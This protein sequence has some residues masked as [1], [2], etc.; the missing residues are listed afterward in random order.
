MS[1]KDTLDR[2]DGLPPELAELYAELS[3]IFLDERPSFGPE[4]RN[5]LAKEWTRPEPRRR[6]AWMR[7]ALAASV[8]ALVFTSLA[9]P[10]ARASLVDGVQAIITTLRG[11]GEA[12][13]TLEEVLFPEEES[14]GEPPLEVPAGA[15]ATV[16]DAGGGDEAVRLPPFQP[17]NC[18]F[19]MLVDAESDRELARRYYPRD[20]QRAG[21]GGTVTLQLWVSETG[22]VDH[23]QLA[24]GSEIQELNTAAL[25]AGRALD[26]QPAMRNG[27]PVGTWVE[28]DLVF[29][30]SA[31]FSFA[32]PEILETPMV[33][34]VD[35]WEPPATWNDAAVIPSP[36]LLESQELLRVALGDEPERLEERFGPLDNILSGEVPEG[37]NA[38]RWREDVTR[39]L[40]EA[41]VRDPENPAPYL[42]LAR[43]RRKQGLRNDA[44][45]LFEEGLKR[46]S[47]GDRPVSPRLIAELSYETG[48]LTREN[49][50]GWRGLGE[51]PAS[52]LTADRCPGM[53]GS[54][55]AVASQETLLAW[56]FYCSEPLG[57]VLES[58]FVTRE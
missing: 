48:R 2:L 51:V 17:G 7:H 37:R 50:L 25:M 28:F 42:A 19:P 9:V 14:A 13:V 21:I 34:E 22:L 20:L 23:V 58:D 11:E 5:E 24:R 54:P 46:A 8:A 45:L 29:E 15:P 43:I 26:F 47:R 49:W 18:S 57:E 39:A 40:G 6:G 44:Q 53:A 35:G 4:L 52:A 16:V 31:T 33:P 36:I 27:V 1:D 3:Q 55:G 10:P 38:M 32:E 41:R 12:E 30:P 56:N